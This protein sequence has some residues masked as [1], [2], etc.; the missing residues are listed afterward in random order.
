MR[1]VHAVSPSFRAVSWS[2]EERSGVT[3][4][5]GATQT[6]ERAACRA[7]SAWRHSRGK[8]SSHVERLPLAP[9][10]LAKDQSNVPSAPTFH[11]SLHLH[12]LSVCFAPNT[13]VTPS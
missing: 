7:R 3:I 8:S 10:L 5:C 4:V 6:E 9:L 1:R 2:C 12:P 13:M 11:L